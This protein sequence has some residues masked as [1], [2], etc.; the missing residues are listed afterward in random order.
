MFRDSSPL[1]SKAKFIALV[2]YGTVAWYSRRSQSC[3]I[4]SSIM[5]QHFELGLKALTS[6]SQE[7][8]YLKVP[9]CII[10]RNILPASS[11][12]F[13]ASTTGGTTETDY[14]PESDDK[15]EEEKQEDGEEEE[16]EKEEKAEAYYH[17]HHQQ[18]YGRREFPPPIPLLAR[19]ENLQGRMPF[20]FKSLSLSMMM[21]TVATTTLSLFHILLR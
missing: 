4:K 8:S 20:V 16:K 12:S 9:C 10:S 19:T 2:V 7:K 13:T 17:R 6:S 3:D 15:R 21:A 14:A 11:S 18:Q 5:R 1:L